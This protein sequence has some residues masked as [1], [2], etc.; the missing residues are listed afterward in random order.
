MAQNLFK[1]HPEVSY[2]SSTSLRARN[3]NT[4]LQHFWMWSFRLLKNQN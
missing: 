1:A 2:N 4:K 3:A